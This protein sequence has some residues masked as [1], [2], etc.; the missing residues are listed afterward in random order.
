MSYKDP[1]DV[2]RPRALIHDVNSNFRGINLKIKANY[3][4]LELFL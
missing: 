3:L 1:E 4:I 2:Q